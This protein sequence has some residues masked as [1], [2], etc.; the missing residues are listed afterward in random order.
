MKDPVKSLNTGVNFD[1]RAIEAWQSRNG[2]DV[3]PLTGQKLG[4]LVE[5]KTLK[6]E[7]AKWKQQIKGYRRVLRGSPTTYFLVNAEQPATRPAPST[8][9]PASEALKEQWAKAKIDMFNGVNEMMT[10][11]TDAGMSD[12][13]SRVVDIDKEHDWSKPIGGGN[14]KSESFK[15]LSNL[16]NDATRAG[17]KYNVECKSIFHQTKLST[18]SPP[19]RTA[20]GALK[21]PP[22]FA[23][24]LTV[25]AKATV[26][27]PPPPKTTTSVSATRMARI[28]ADL[29]H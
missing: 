4:P 27:P 10:S 17:Y 6:T 5:N 21:A 20:V 19:L 16:V 11:F 1:R 28:P 3:C 15:Q 26:S 12:Y 18:N 23:T 25:S 29:F 13:M 7:I 8:A 9:E 24:T 2:D 14:S 22:T